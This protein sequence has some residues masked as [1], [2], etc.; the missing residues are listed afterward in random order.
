MNTIN[1]TFECIKRVKL[2]A[3]IR[4]V[5]LLLAIGNAAIQIFGIDA[6]DIGNETAEKAASV[7]VLI[8]TAATAYWKNNSF[9][10]AAQAADE[11]LQT[12]RSTQK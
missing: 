9:T 8:I 4:L 1:K 12:I 11:I 7:A 10:E 2:S 5:V 6:V 3:W